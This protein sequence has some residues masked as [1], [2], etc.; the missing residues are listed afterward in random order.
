MQGEHLVPGHDDLGPEEVV[1]APDGREDG[2]HSQSRRRQRQD[3]LPVDAPFAGAVDARRVQQFIGNREHILAQQ[4]DAGGRA[5]S[6]DDDAD[7]LVVPAQR[8]DQQESRHQDDRERHHQRADDEHEDDAPPA[9]AVFAQGESGH[10]VDE[11]RQDSGGGG[12]DDAVGQITPEVETLNATAVIVQAEADAFHRLAV[13][14]FDLDDAGLGICRVD[15]LR[16]Q[17]DAALLRE[18]RD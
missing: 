1:P 8:G 14:Q 13:V 12:D 17:A 9:E 3:H 6:R 15:H 16:F 5:D 18:L 10:A 7:E 2:Q 11:E 4:E